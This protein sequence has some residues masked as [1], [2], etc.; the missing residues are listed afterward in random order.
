MSVTLDVYEEDAE[1]TT[2][3]GEPSDSDD[4]VWAEGNCSSC[5]EHVEY[6]YDPVGII[7]FKDG[8]PV[9]ATPGS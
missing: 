2:A 8:G 7:A 1:Y 9:Y 3:D 5:G 4:T 6:D